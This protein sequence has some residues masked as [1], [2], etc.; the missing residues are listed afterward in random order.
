M[1]LSVILAG[2]LAQTPPATPVQ[3]SV[4]VAAPAPVVAP[5]PPPTPAERNAALAAKKVGEIRTSLK[6]PGLNLQA[7]NKI[8]KTLLH[9]EAGS[10]EAFQVMQDERDQKEQQ[11][12]IVKM[13]PIWLEQQRQNVQF[14]IE[15]A[16]AQ[17]LQ[18][19][20]MTAEKKRQSDLWFQYQQN[21]IMADEARSLR[22]MASP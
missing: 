17:A 7:K 9:A 10:R 8:K 4:A 5:A 6:K 18:Q 1:L 19:M 12:F 20:A 15:S 16:K 14:N 11:A 3:P 21:Q 2:L 22:Q 13:M